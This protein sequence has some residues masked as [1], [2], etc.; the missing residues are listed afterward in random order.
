MHF[1]FYSGRNLEALAEED[2]EED[3]EEHVGDEVCNA[4]ISSC[5]VFKVFV[6]VQSL[7][8]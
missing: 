6:Q 1:Y 4:R 8:I 5:P 3:M 7:I 2:D